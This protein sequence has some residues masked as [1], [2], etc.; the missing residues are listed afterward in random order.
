MK[1]TVD[2]SDSS[3]YNKFVQIALEKS[4]RLTTELKGS[5][6]L[7][8]CLNAGLDIVIVG[9]NDFYSQRNKV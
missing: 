3:S 5:T 9:D 4:L 6:Y 1:A 8:E 7:E 2:S